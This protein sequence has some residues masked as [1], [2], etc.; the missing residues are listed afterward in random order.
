[1]AGF[2]NFLALL[3]GRAQSF[4]AG[5]DGINLAPAHA[6]SDASGNPIAGGNPLPT[7]DAAAEAALATIAAAEATGNTTLATIA[8]ALAGTLAVTSGAYLGTDASNA[9]PAAGNILQTATAAH[10]FYVQNQSAVALQVILDNGAGANVTI[11]ALDPSTYGAGRQGA[12]TD[13]IPFAGRVRVA[14]T[15]GSQFA[16]RVW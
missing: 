4:L 5:T 8:T 14:G 15:A 11:L 6:L 7:Q 3:N 9:A 1:M 10:G 16:F 13:P 12:S 2:T